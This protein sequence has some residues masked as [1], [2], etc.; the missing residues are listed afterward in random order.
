MAFYNEFQIHQIEVICDGV[1]LLWGLLVEKDTQTCAEWMR[2]YNGDHMLCYLLQ[3]YNQKQ[4]FH[5][6]FLNIF[7]NY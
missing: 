3:M 1:G 6:H 4:Y 2:F 5:L 7:D